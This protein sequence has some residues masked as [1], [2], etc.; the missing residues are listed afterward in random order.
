[1]VSLVQVIIEKCGY[2]LFL[3]KPNGK[4]REK[5]KSVVFTFSVDYQ[6]LFIHAS[7]FVLTKILAMIFKK[8]PTHAETA[9]VVF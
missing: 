2:S 1:M 6:N 8:T 9:I 3:Q 5:V 7:L 4:S